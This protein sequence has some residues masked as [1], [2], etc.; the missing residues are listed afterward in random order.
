MQAPAHR[1]LISAITHMSISPLLQEQIYSP[2]HKLL[3]PLPVSSLK[4][5]YFNYVLDVWGWA[6]AVLVLREAAC[7][8]IFREL[9]QHYGLGL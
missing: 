6:C 8:V 5:T 4:P 1:L 3:G 9:S 2:G 7:E